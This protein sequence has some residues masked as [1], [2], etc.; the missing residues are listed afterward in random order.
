[1]TLRTP[2]RPK[3]RASPA[4]HAWFVDEVQALA[5]ALKK[6]GSVVWQF[7]KPLSDAAMGAVLNEASGVLPAA[8]RDLARAF[9]GASFSWKWKKEG[10]T[11][12]HGRLEIPTLERALT[13]RANAPA[14]FGLSWPL[15]VDT[16][17]ADLVAVTDGED[18]GLFL[19]DRDEGYWLA[20]GL[21]LDD[22]LR[23]ALDRL[24]LPGWELALNQSDLLPEGAADELEACNETA[25]RVREALG[26]P[27]PDSLR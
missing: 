11:Q 6:E 2:K 12:A 18:L 10:G 15:V 19:F 4:N 20:D 17:H 3:A 5:R 16:S 7:G 24:A 9:N 13:L 23:A 27:I 8:L 22:V 1:V 21:E 14:E 25:V 26:L